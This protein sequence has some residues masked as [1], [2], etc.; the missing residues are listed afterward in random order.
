M[1][2]KPVQKP[3]IIEFS[4]ILLDLKIILLDENDFFV[5]CKLRTVNHRLPIEC[6]RWQNL[7]REN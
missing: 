2:F 5:F 7:E 3:L 4:N 1:I 6:S